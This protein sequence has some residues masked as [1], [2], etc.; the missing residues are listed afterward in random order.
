[1]SVFYTFWGIT[2]GP[3]KV[4]APLHPHPDSGGA[5][6]AAFLRCVYLGCPCP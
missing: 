4:R 3:Q 1:M 5:S 2:Y 6:Q